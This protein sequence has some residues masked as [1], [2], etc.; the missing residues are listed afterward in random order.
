MDFKKCFGWMLRNSIR[1]EEDQPTRNARLFHLK[2]LIQL[3][4]HFQL[5]KQQLSEELRDQPFDE[6]LTSDD[7]H[8]IQSN[9]K[10]P[11]QQDYIILA[12]AIDRIAFL[13]YCFIFIV[14][15]ITYS[16]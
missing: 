14:L 6:H 3:I 15:A 4:Q 11:I 9:S 1:I 7:H 8:I 5:P 2:M 16:I 12:T 10:G 13:I